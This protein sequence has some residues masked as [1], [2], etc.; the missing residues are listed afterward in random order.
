MDE[1]RLEYDWIDFHPENVSG[2]GTYNLIVTNT[3][4]GKTCRDTATVMVTSSA[5]F[6]AANATGGD[7]YLYESQCNLTSQFS[8]PGVNYH[9]AGPGITAANQFVQNPM[10]TVAGNYT[11]SVNQPSNGC[12]STAL[13][14][15]IPND[16]LPNATAVGGT[17]SC[18][19]PNVTLDGGSNIA[20]ASYPGV[21][22]ESMQ[23][24]KTRK[25]RR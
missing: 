16:T 11:I 5:A 12:T 6:P 25:T 15:V 20:N 1:R 7:Y 23:A 9:W 10:V 19:Q 24:I 2:V 18:T 21:G 13:A 8:S 17:I 14:V 4:G 3:V 22:Q